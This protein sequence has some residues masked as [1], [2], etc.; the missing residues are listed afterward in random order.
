MNHRAAGNAPSSS[1]RTDTTAQPRRLGETHVC[2]PTDMHP[3]RRATMDI[4][5][6]HRLAAPRLRQ[7]DLAAAFE[8]ISITCTHIVIDT[9]TPR[10]RSRRQ[11]HRRCRRR[12]RTLCRCRLPHIPSIHCGPKAPRATVA[13]VGAALAIGGNSLGGGGAV[14][15][16][17]PDGG[18]CEHLSSCLIKF[19]RAQ[20]SI[21]NC[22]LCGNET[23][24]CVKVKPEQPPPLVSIP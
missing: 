15:G 19:L 11:K 3:P 22:P 9:H 7:A 24:E 14:G 17:E 8:A 23:T 1:N 5:V 10:G 12:A 2:L 18:K 20:A 16:R 6:P 13:Q 4:V 21:F